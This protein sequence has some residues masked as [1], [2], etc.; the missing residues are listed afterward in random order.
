MHKKQMNGYSNNTMFIAPTGVLGSGV[1][2]A[3]RGLL[4]SVADRGVDKV[5]VDGTGIDWMSSEGLALL[6]KMNKAC[7]EANI[8]FAICG[9]NASTRESLELVNL[10]MVLTLFDDLSQAMGDEAAA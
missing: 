3:W 5:L 2:S 10:H 9:L 8:Q 4:D 7:Q 6:V 1:L